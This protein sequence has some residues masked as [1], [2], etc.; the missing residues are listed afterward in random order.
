MRIIALILSLLFLCAFSPQ[1]ME[2]ASLEEQV[3]QIIRDHP[4]VIVESVQKYETEQRQA[5][6]QQQKQQQQ[7]A[8]QGLAAQPEV[9][10]G[11]SPTKGAQDQTKILLEF[12]DFECPFCAMSAPKVSQFVEEYSEQVTLVYKHFPLTNIHEQAQ[13]AAQASWAAQQQD[14]FWEYHDAL[15]A[16]QKDLGETLYIEIAEQLNLKMKRFNR[17][18]NSPEAIAA[19]QADVALG[20]Q[21]GIGGTP[22]FVLDGQVLDLP[23]N[24][25][26]MEKLLKTT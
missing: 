19:I 18:R 9:L 22:F 16:Q 2:A 14:K 1:G 20:K 13:A 26:V 12:S 10:I 11:A 6:Q 23:L 24:P 3:L 15:F 8:L 4:E 17:D 25:A 7:S 21:I 5:K